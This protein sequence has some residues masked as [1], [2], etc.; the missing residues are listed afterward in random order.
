VH[1]KTRCPKD[2]IVLAEELRELKEKRKERGS[3]KTWS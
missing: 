3:R 1:A 2:I